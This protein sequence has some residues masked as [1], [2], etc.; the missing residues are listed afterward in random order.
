MF[1]TQSLVDIT[2]SPLLDTVLTNCP[3]RIFLPNTNALEENQKKTYEMFGL[4]KRQIEIIAS[5]VPKRQYYYDSPDGSRLFDLALEYCPYTLSYVAVDKQA[6]NHLD[7]IL[8]EYGLKEFNHRWLIDHNLT[9]PED[10]QKE[11]F[12]L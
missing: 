11:E 2:K 1:A 5:A 6:L 4:N 7:A 10:I 8:K 9:Y 12:V 3:S